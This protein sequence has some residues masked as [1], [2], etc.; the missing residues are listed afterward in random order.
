MILDLIYQLNWYGVL[1]SIVAFLQLMLLLFFRQI[2]M[3]TSDPLMVQD[4]SAF[5]NVS[6]TSS[7]LLSQHT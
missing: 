3:L 4:V 5:F 6:L 1:K 2:L 7:I